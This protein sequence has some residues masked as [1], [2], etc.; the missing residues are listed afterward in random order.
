MLLFT[1]IL[2]LAIKYLLKFIQFK[3]SPVEYTFWNFSSGSCNTNV[4]LQ[5]LAVSLI[6]Q[7]WFT[8]ASLSKIEYFTQQ[9]L[10]LISHVAKANYWDQPRAHVK[11]LDAGH[12][13]CQP[14]GVTNNT[15]YFSQN[16]DFLQLESDLYALFRIM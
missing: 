14:V 10:L 5:D 7:I 15:S 3:C 11:V 13:M 6:I 8:T 2:K 16:V 12:I 1:K 4:V 9:E